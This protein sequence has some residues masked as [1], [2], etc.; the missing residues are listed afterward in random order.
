[1]LLDGHIYIDVILA[2]ENYV[3]P[4]FVNNNNKESTD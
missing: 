3:E 1:M 4:F 2:Y